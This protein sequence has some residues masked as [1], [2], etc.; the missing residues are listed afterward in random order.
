MQKDVRC[1]ILAGI[2]IDGPRLAVFA[3]IQVYRDR[4]LV[5]L[6]RVGCINSQGKVSTPI[7]EV[8][9]MLNQTQGFAEEPDVIQ[10]AQEAA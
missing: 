3:E 6:S 8:H 4:I 10:F 7:V 5:C 2:E 9:L 1:R